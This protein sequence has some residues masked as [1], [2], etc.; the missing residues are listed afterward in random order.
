MTTKIEF[1][2]RLPNAVMPERAT[3]HS[4]AFDLRAADVKFDSVQGLAIVDTGLSTQFPEGYVLYVYGRSGF[5]AKYGIRLANCTGVIDA[6]Y[7][8]PLMVMLTV[9]NPTHF[10]ELTKHIKPGERIAQAILVKLPDVEWV[11]VDGLEETVRGE[12]GF[13]ST[14]TS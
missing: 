9:N 10:H 1:V 13:G 11:E 5:A 14:G 6:D 12:G 2:R 3:P 8:G 7:R 4:A